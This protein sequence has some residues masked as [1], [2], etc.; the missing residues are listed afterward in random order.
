MSSRRSDSA[1]RSHWTSAIGTVIHGRVASPASSIRREHLLGACSHCARCG[2]RPR[3]QSAAVGVCRTADW[4]AAAAILAVVIGVVAVVLRLDQ[5]TAAVS[6][7]VNNGRVELSTFEVLT[8][9]EDATRFTKRLTDEI[10]RGFGA[11][12]IKAIAPNESPAANG[13]AT[14][15][16][17]EFL[18]RGTVDRDNDQFVVNAELLHRRD[19]LMVGSTTLRQDSE[20]NL[21]QF[22]QRVATTLALRLQCGLGLRTLAQGDSSSE[23][24]AA[25]VG[26][27]ANWNYSGIEQQP[28]LARRIVEVAP[29]YAI[30]YAL[31]A[32][33]NAYQTI[34]YPQQ[35]YRPDAEVVRLRTSAYDNA[36]IAMERDPKHMSGIVDLAFAIIDDPSRSLAER[37]ELLRR[38]LSVDSPFQGARLWWYAN[39][40]D[41]VGRTDEARSYYLR[42][43]KEFP[44]SVFIELQ[45]LFRSTELVAAHDGHGDIE[46]ARE[47]FAQLDQTMPTDGARLRTEFWYGDPAVAKQLVRDP[48]YARLLDPSMR[49]CFDAVSDAKSIGRELSVKEI[50]AACGS[51]SPKLQ[52]EGVRETAIGWYGTH[53]LAEIYAEFGHLDEAYAPPEHDGIFWI[54][55]E[56]PNLFMPYMRPFRADARFMPLVASHGLVDYWL[57]SGHWPDFCARDKL[58]YD[59]KEAAFGVRA[60]VVNPRGFLVDEQSRG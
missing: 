57:D 17:A 58:P 47:E 5:R 31:L 22:Q 1:R 19:G 27:C 10:R 16:P 59:C 40:L 49:D 35:N 43:G 26:W 52:F 12:G 23:L 7:D 25:L 3:R 42:A 30:G 46:A 15:V 32:L 29:Q 11:N 37:E 20:E 2:P 54:R 18:L 33:S 50:D 45:P 4:L 53:Q 55:S 9:V 28:E 56:V 38:S 34:S 39:F 60:N 48:R 8:Q 21:A 6:N 13:S 14:P 44:L 36:K 41:R 24:F 51:A